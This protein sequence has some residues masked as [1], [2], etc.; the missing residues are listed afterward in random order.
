MILLLHSL[1]LFWDISC[2]DMLSYARGF[3]MHVGLLL[4]LACLCVS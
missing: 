3:R 2:D 1:M 4:S